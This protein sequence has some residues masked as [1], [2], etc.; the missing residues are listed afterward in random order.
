ME[1]GDS[2]ELEPIT[3]DTATS[4]L[5]R[6]A[7]LGEA[8]SQRYIAANRLAVK[9]KGESPLVA[10]TAL[11]EI[12]GLREE[13]HPKALY[14]A[15]GEITGNVIGGVKNVQIMELVKVAVSPGDEDVRQRA[16]A[17]VVRA[18]KQEQVLRA[19]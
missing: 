8:T 2:V 19:A 1:P 4:Q 15:M 10:A 12:F 6:E 9:V 7:V 17:R 16:M 3:L 5:I 11:A 13:A 14:H 18:V